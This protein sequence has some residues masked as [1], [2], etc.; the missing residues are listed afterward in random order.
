MARA[1]AQVLFSECIFMRASE[2][3]HGLATNIRML[4]STM[5]AI[6]EQRIKT[7]DLYVAGQRNL[8]SGIC[9]RISGCPAD[10]VEEDG[11]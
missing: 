4:P 2:A 7:T 6:V 1:I 9:C 11:F 10:Q 3:I 8:Y 5:K